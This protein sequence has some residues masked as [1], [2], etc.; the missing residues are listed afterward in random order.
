MVNGKFAG[1]RVVSGENVDEDEFPTLGTPARSPGGTVGREAA[2]EFD[3]DER[4][5]AFGNKSD[6]LLS[7]LNGVASIAVPLFTQNAGDSPSDLSEMDRAVMGNIVISADVA[8]Y[9]TKGKELKAMVQDV[10]VTPMTMTSPVEVVSGSE[11][12]SFEGMEKGLPLLIPGV[13]LKPNPRSSRERRSIFFV[14][15]G[16]EAICEELADMVLEQYDPSYWGYSIGGIPDAQS[17]R[18]F[19][20]VG[21]KPSEVRAVLGVE[22]DSVQWKRFVAKIAQE[23]RMLERR[24]NAASEEAAKAA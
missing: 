19:L 21:L 12:A 22:A 13:K 18:F 3:R 8:A 14:G 15:A 5:P 17:A 6:A 9:H 7:G 4:V 23:N 11:M 1:P 2:D 10:G 24:R 16:N 20:F